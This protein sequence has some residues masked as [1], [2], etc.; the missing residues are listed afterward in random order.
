MTSILTAAR[1]RCVVPVILAG[2][3]LGCGGGTPAP[4]L[5][6]VSGKVLMDDKPLAGVT[7]IFNPLQGTPGTGGYA[8]TDPDGTYTLLHQTQKPGCEPGQYGVTFTK[9][10]QPD[11]SPIP[12]NAKRGE[13]GM[14]EQM[15]KAYTIF[16]P[17]QVVEMAKIDGPTTAQNFDLKSNKKMPPRMGR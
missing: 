16:D 13:V 11:G 7:V 6:P 4:K 15:P 12:M 8:V 17:Y 1:P 10:T 9:M 14:V 2:L 5:I 3:L